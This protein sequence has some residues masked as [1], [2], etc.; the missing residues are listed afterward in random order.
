MVCY[1]M[2]C[3][4]VLCYVML[5]SVLFVLHYRRFR[6]QLNRLYSDAPLLRCSAPALRTWLRRTLSSVMLMLCYV[7]LCHVMLCYVMLCYVRLC[8]V[9]LC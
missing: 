7:M 1:V 6:R 9:M 3:Y 2:L 4:V 8:Y 5:C